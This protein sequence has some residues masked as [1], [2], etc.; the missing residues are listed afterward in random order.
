MLV[1]CID[2]DRD[3][4]LT[5][6]YEYAYNEIYKRDRILHVKYT[7]IELLDVAYADTNVYNE[8]SYWGQLNRWWNGDPKKIILKIGGIPLYITFTKYPLID[9]YEFDA[10]YGNGALRTVIQ[11]LRFKLHNR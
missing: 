6:L 2:L 4:V 7:P 10:I 8:D 11:E 5:A 9:S 3:V 1:N